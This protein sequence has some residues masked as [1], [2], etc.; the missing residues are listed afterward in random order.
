M[1]LSGDKKRDYQ[2]EYMR[3]YMHKRRAVKTP[4]RPIVKTQALHT[5]K[6]ETLDKL[7][8]TMQSIED[9]AKAPQCPSGD[10]SLPLYNP[11]IHG[12]GDRVLV[13]PLYGKK[14]VATVLPELDAGGQPIPNYD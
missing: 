10:A 11:A 14:L 9:R 1:A 3:D 2:R 5:S 8:K 6:Q 4:L 13:K 12:P 7:R